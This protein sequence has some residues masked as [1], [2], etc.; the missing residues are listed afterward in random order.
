MQ[1]QNNT[2]AVKKKRSSFR[3]PW[4]LYILLLPA[5]TYTFI[6]HYLPMYGVQIAFK[7]YQ[8]GKGIWGS[9]W[10]GLQHFRR[11]LSY[12]A[13]WE[14]IRNTLSIT[15]YSLATF[16]LAIIFALLINPTRARGTALWES[17]V[18]KPRGKDSREKHRS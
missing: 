4:E 6:F 2:P 13:F 1:M 15:L 8:T 3:K 14:M 5:M 7:N 18:G 17:L 11:F 12:P 10:V 9:S 16:P